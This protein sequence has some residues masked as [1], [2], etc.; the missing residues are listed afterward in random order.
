MKTVF[1]ERVA[2]G[3]CGKCGKENDS[4]YSYCLGCRVD[5]NDQKD[6]RQA[7]GECV[8][9]GIA[10]RP[11]AG[12]KKTTCMACAEKRRIYKASYQA[13]KRQEAAEAGNCGDCFKPL[14]GVEGSRCVDCRAKRAACKKRARS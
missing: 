4:V 3:L 5:K 10:L 13:R 6:V 9:C 12:E 7:C 14:G 8:T 11:W 2:I 1:K